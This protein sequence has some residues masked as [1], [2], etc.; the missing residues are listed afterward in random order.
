MEE[1]EKQ[2]EQFLN[3]LNP[4]S[5]ANDEIGPCAIKDLIEIDPLKYN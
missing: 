4:N 2:F 3:R 1:Y 5:S